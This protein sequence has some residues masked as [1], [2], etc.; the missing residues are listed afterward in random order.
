MNEQPSTNRFSAEAQSPRHSEERFR[1]L[2]EGVRDYAIFL[3]DPDGYVSSWNSGAERIKGYKADE[4]IGQHFSV[5]YPIERILEK[6]PEHELNVA[7]TEERFEEEGWRLRKDSTRFWANIV[8]TALYD[9]NREIWAF[10]KVTRDLT[11]KK[12]I[13]ALEIAERQM[14]EFLAMLSHELRNPLAPIRNATYM[15]QMKHLDDPELRWSRDVIDRQ[16]THLTRLIDDLLEV[17]RIISGNIRLQVEQWDIAAMVTGAIESTRPLMD[18]RRHIL[19]VILPS[20]TLLV[21]GDSTR[22][23]QVLVNLLNNAAKYTPEGGRITLS[24]IEQGDMVSIS[25]RDNGT[26]ISA[27]LL[28]KVFDLFTQGERTLDR[29]DGGLGIGL[30]LVRRLVAMHSGTV[31]ASSDG[32]GQGSE[33]VVELPLINVAI[34]GEDPVPPATSEAKANP[35]GFRV[36]VVDD[37]MDAA[38]SMMMFLKIWGYNVRIAHDGISTLEAVSVYHPH[39]ILLD[40]GLPGLNGY[41]VAER[42]SQSG[43]LEHMVLIALTGY[44]QEEDRRRTQK[45]GFTHHLVKPVDPIALEKLLASICA[46]MKAKQPSQ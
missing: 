40:I 36:L 12:R 33:F 31:R 10:A 11:E 8:I 32:P 2:V 29:S 3:L 35:P 6:W 9:E 20:R 42:L 15:L 14:T 16:V 45:A 23:T 25:V 24:V 21:N 43:D 46:A 1:L 27:D 28:E 26:G 44:G 19:E 38:T 18:A 39:I 7:R 4:I 41:E 34:D 37:N 17:S 5:F 30:T 22:L 13:E